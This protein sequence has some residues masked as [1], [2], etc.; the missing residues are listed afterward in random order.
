MILYFP[1]FWMETMNQYFGVAVKCIIKDSHWKILLV[2]K[3]ETEDVNPNSFDIP[4]W[5][6]HWGEKLEDAIKRE[7]KE[8]VNLEVEIEKVSRGRWFTKWDL[9]LIWITYVGK[10]SDVSNIKL[11]DEH[12]WYFRYDK[13]QILNGDF[14]GRLKEEVQSS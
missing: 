6:I 12:T 10:C 2:Y 1:H 11:S 5:R 3:S 8:E 13:E 7:V 9:H 4:G 14:P